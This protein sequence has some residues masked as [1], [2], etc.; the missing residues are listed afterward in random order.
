MDG[1]M[2]ETG[3]IEA[4][5]SSESAASS[6]ADRYRRLQVGFHKYGYPLLSLVRR[7]FK[8]RYASTVLGLGW[9]VAQPLAFLLLYTVVFS[10]IMKV[11][12]RPVDDT[13]SSSIYLVCGLLPYVSLVESIHRGSMCLRENRSLIEK[14]IF[15]AEVLPAVPVIS[16]AIT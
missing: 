5:A 2:K 9:A 13:F 12:F 15:P 6:L 3:K 1:S 7:D 10:V 4:L 14:V 11:R 16:S 8:T